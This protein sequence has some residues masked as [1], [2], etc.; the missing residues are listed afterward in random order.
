MTFSSVQVSSK[1][2][3][4]TP[5]FFFEKKF[6]C[7]KLPYL[8]SDPVGARRRRALSDPVGAW[9]RRVRRRRA[10]TGVVGLKNSAAT[11]PHTDFFSKNELFQKSAKPSGARGFAP[12]SEAREFVCASLSAA[13][14]SMRL[15]AC[16]SYAI[17]KVRVQ[18]ANCTVIGA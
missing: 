13:H 4:E 5:P 11:R 17:S 12:W 14:F 3:E 2:P 16:H 9:R 8:W 18:H 15:T 7:Q 6:I 1:P 10:P